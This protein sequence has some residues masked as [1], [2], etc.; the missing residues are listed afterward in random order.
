MTAEAILGAGSYVVV[1]H[2]EDGTYTADVIQVDDSGNYT[3][4]QSETYSDADGDGTFTGDKGGESSSKPNEGL[5]EGEETDDGTTYSY[6]SESDSGASDTEDN[7]ADTDSGTD[8]DTDDVDEYT[9]GP[10]SETT[11][12]A[13]QRIAMLATL[14]KLLGDSKTKPGRGGND[15]TP[16]P[17]NE[18]L[19]NG[20]LPYDPK[21]T[22]KRPIDG[23]S[24]NSGANVP[25]DALQQ[26][27][28]PNK[29]QGDVIDPT[30]IDQ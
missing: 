20:T 1:T 11:L 12:T 24:L 10:D 3:V 6:E 8:P 23:S 5:Y 15:S 21:D 13:A 26:I 4:V 29:V 7:S 27:Q 28:D 9:P 2:N 22:V 25:L 16:N 17:M 30:K 19:G 14:Q 18:S